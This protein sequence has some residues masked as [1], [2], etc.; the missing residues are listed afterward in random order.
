M[1]YIYMRKF[2]SESECK[3]LFSRILDSTENT[4]N[5]SGHLFAT[6]HLDQLRTGFSSNCMHS[7]WLMLIRRLMTSRYRVQHGQLRASINTSK[8]MEVELYKS[9]RPSQ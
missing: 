2:S 6:F 7:F 5:D 8:L 9:D 1:K 3:F 4:Q